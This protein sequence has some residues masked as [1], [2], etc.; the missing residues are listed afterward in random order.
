[1]GKQV[2]YLNGKRVQEHL[3]GY[4]PFTVQLTE[5]GVQPGD[6]CLLAVMTDNSD[7]KN[8]PPGKRQYTLDFA[9][10][11]GIYRDVW[12]IGKSS[13]AITD[14]LEADKVAAYMTLYTALVT[15]AKAAAPMVPF[16]AEAIYQNLVRSIDKTAPESI[17]LCDFPTVE[18]KWIDKELESKMDEIV[19]I[20]E[21]GR[22]AR[23]GANRKNRQPLAEMYVKADK[24]LDGFYM[25]I[26]REELNIKEVIFT[27]E[28]EGFV[29]Y[30][31]KPQLKT[32]GPKYGKQ[33]GKIREALAGLDGRAAKAI[34]DSEGKLSFDFGEGP[35]EL[36]ADDL[37]IE[38]TQREGFYTVSDRDITVAIDTV[39]TP[40]LIEEGFMR[41]II[42]KVQ[43]MRKEA[44]FE[45]TDHIRITMEGSEKVTAVAEAKKA[46][47]TSAT[48]AESLTVGTPVGYTKEWDLNGEK[49]TLGVE[50]I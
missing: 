25:D 47:I 4:L 13:V 23:N 38:T 42:S 5:Q 17:H 45:V 27:K 11:G 31:F 3:G 6:S 8:F 20:V 29:S 10:H 33:L 48:L 26:I 30:N 34:L 50:K 32:V 21:L 28:V 36:T 16:L 2:I 37:L 7:D 24:D 44:G 49:A 14:A 43:T 15:I 18:E 1:M 19:R 35:V 9:Y 41:E 40:P 39:L 22:A 12:M 46:E